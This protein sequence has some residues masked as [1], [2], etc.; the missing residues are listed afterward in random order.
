LCECL[1]TAVLENRLEE[2]GRTALAEDTRRA[3]EALA[4]LDTSEA[5]VLQQRF[6]LACRALAG[7]PGTRE[8]LIEAL[9]RNLARRLDLCLQMEVAAGLDSPAEFSEAR[10]RLQVSRL[11]D[12][13]SHRQ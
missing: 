2:A 5:A 9:P 10:L 13:L 6:E 11:T 4:P 12:A 1:E 8:E 7:E 3:W